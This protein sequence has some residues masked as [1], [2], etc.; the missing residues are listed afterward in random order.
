MCPLPLEPPS[1][2]SRLSQSAG[3]RSL[4]H[5]NF[6][7]VACRTYSGVRVSAALYICPTLSFPLCPQVCK[8]LNLNGTREEA[9]GKIWIITKWTHKCS[10][11]L[12]KKEK[13]GIRWLTINSQQRIGPQEDFP[14]WRKVERTDVDLY[15]YCCSVAKSCP[16][17]CDPMDCSMPGFPVLHYL[18]EF[19]QTHSHWVG[20]AIQLSHLLSSPS[21]AFNLSQHQALHIRRPKYWSFSISLLNEY[22]GLTSF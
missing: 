15:Y 18:P 1:P 8:R 14:W 7:S 5:S 13:L 16:T 19:P 20:D 2:P 6:P 12:S 3:L 17:L 21:P 9:E 11:N 22:S 10:T 4:L